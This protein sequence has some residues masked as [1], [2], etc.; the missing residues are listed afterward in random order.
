VSGASPSPHEPDPPMS[1]STGTVVLLGLWRGFL[2]LAL[3]AAV[4]E[5]AALAVYVAAGRP[6]R[7]WSFAKIGWLYL[8]SFSRVGLEV[9]LSL[10][11]I[12]GASAAVS[13]YRVHVAFLLGTAFAAW[14]LFRAGGAAAR[15]AEGRPAHRVFAGALIAPGYSLPAFLLGFAAAIRLPEIAVESIRPVAWQALVFPLAMAAVVGAAGGL[16]ASH[17]RLAGARPWGSRALSWAE[18]GWRML[19]ISIGLALVGLL[20]LAALHPAAVRTYV[21]WHERSGRTGAIAFVHEALALPNIGVWLATPSM[22][23]CDVA[24]SGMSST[25]ILCP[26][27]VV[28]PSHVSQLELSRIRLPRFAFLFLLVPAGA[29]LAGGAT[30]G[31]R[32]RSNGERALRGLGAG[33]AFAALAGGAAWLAG[34]ELTGTT[35]SVGHIGFSRLGPRPWQT[36]ALALVWGVAGG[37]AG[38]LMAGALK[39]GSP[40]P[41]AFES[42]AQDGEGVP[43][44]VPA[45]P[46]E[47]VPPS[48]TSV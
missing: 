41:L 9:R 27:G 5:T 42:D 47:P 6:F 29:A 16:W 1:S 2:A 35:S 28:D 48:P 36:A 43:D 7:L 39:S 24:E 40:S 44:D 20:V 22:G 10:G 13:V 3:T 46:E 15:R 25:S 31:R 30:A 23:G 34:V 17:D 8:L 18:G 19:V 14:V 4:A 45:E 37:V 12:L 21:Q 32:A 38:A 11:S 33:V 26:G